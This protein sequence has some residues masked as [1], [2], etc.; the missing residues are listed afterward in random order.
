MIEDPISVVIGGEDYL[1]PPM[2]FYCLERAWPHIQRLSR[3]ATLNQVVQQAQRRLAAA[4]AGDGLASASAVAAQAALDDAQAT[5]E[6][7][8]GDFIGQTHEALAVI[9]AA[10]SLRT[11]A[12]SLEDLAKRLR[13]DEI[14]G[15]HEACTLL[16]NSSGLIGRSTPGES[17]AMSRTPALLN[18]TGSSPN[19]LLTA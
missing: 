8:G 11:P 19:S 2:S 16:M 4:E 3:M 9:A 5:V 17:A 1:C 14:T 15:I 18:G 12:P 7:A 10:L 13:A 6:K